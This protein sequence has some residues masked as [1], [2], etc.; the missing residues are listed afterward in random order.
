MPSHPH[1]TRRAQEMFS[2]VE[3]YHDSSLTQKAFCETEKLAL[4]TLQYWISKYKKYRQPSSGFAEAFVQI[5]AQS[6]KPS[7]NSAI[8]LSYPNGVTV[9]LSNDVELTLVKE[10]IRL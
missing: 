8:I 6:P 2:V 3:R 10:L 7:A 1:L 9:R 4:S 5:K